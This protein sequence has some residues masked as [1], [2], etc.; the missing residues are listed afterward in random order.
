LR[1]KIGKTFDPKLA[2]LMAECW[3]ESP[4]QRPEFSEIL[5]RLREIREKLS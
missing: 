5:G 2:Q 4:E 1:P 3:D